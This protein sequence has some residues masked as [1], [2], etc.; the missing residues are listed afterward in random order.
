MMNQDRQLEVTM[1]P[2]DYVAGDADFSGDVSLADAVY[3]I[4]FVFKGGPAPIPFGSG[5]ANCD[6]QLNLA[7]AVY[8]INYVFK[9]GPPPGC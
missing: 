7:D 8:L 2:G 6:L 9:G 4:N 1:Y 3:I 5:D